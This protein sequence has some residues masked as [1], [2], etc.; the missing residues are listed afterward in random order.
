MYISKWERRN[1]FFEKNY[2][3]LSIVWGFSDT[4]L[5]ILHHACFL[6]FSIWVVLLCRLW[7]ACPGIL[8]TQVVLTHDCIISSL[9]MFTFIPSVGLGPECCISLGSDCLESGWKVLHA[10]AQLGRQK[11]WT[12]TY[13]AHPMSLTCKGMDNSL[14][15]APSPRIAFYLRFWVR[16][17]GRQR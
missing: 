10:R 17:R 1:H 2:I 8:W 6:S 13:S 3:E 7:T 5:K 9:P 14:L 11:W 12:Q 15:R 4:F 16:Q